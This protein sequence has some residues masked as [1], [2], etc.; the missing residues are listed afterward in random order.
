[1][2]A[3]HLFDQIG[4]PFNIRTPGRNRTAQ[5]IAIKSGFKPKDRQD[6]LLFGD[7]HI[8]PAER[9]NPRGPQ[10]LV[11]LPGWHL[12]RDGQLRGFTTADIQNHPAGNFCAP[13]N[14]G[15]VNATLKAIARIG[16]NTELATG[17]C[18]P[19]WIKQGDFKENVC[20]GFAASG[21]HTTHNATDTLRAIIIGD[22]NHAVFKS[23]FTLIESFELLTRF[24]K[25]H[26]EITTHLVS[27]EHMQRS[28]EI[29]CRPVGD[30]NQRRYRPQ[31][32]GPQTI[33][34]P[35]RAFAIFYV[36]KSPTDHHRTGVSRIAG[37]ITLPLNSA[38][39]ATCDFR[40]VQRLQGAEPRR[41][42]IT[43]NP[44]H[45]GTI[46]A[47][48]CQRDINHRIIKT[49]PFRPAFADRRI[50]RQFD[51]AFMII[52]QP[53]FAF[54]AQ[55]TVGI[56]TADLGR[57]EGHIGTRNIAAAWREDA[58]HP[59]ARIGSTANHLLIAIAG[60]DDT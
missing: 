5:L 60:I 7:R 43:R 35:L 13:L 6:C 26:C 2:D 3:Q 21:G 38:L 20:S 15:R 49:S 14:R 24:G 59:G 12:T 58:F 22:Y 1:M 34:Q 16:N 29:E 57:L 39:K 41:S 50:V 18:D 52:R 31:T 44:A 42:K 30:I 23:V 11:F 55:H 56:F 48:W 19:N 32:N 4:F 46:T 25:P 37:K 27:I 45:A 33:L 36:A 54:G 53:H 28:A 51:N 10:C 9:H 8:D 47:I 40:L 17:L